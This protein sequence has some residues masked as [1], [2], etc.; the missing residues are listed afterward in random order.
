MAWDTARTKQ[1]LLDAAVEEFAEYG[2]EGARVARVATGAGVNK[3]RIYQYFGNK[4]KLFAAVL[5]AEMAKLATAVPL[6]P[7][8]AADLGDYA[9]RTYDYHRAHP[10]FLRLL[11]WEG[12]MCQDR[13][14][15]EYERTEHY[16][17]KVAAIA[18]AQRA[19]A[20]TADVPPA[21]LMH[22]VIALTS[23]WFTLPQIARMLLPE[24]PAGE[25]GA[26]PDARRGMLVALTRR[27][28]SPGR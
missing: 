24:P 22:T 12:L 26:G 8:Q 4:E 7:Q 25:A 11:A 23:S 2:P 14:V 15:A 16:A 13:V 19:G 1:L 27:L 18:E 9:G 21:Q 3:E 6:T 20:L 5:E 28:T 17:L 10:H